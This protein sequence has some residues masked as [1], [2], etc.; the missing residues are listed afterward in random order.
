MSI[1]IYHIMSGLTLPMGAAHL[2]TSMSPRLDSRWGG[3]FPLP[4][5]ELH[6]LEAPGIAW[7]TE[8]RF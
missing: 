2:V 8:E 3:S 7:R 6:P 1:N 4:G 5:R